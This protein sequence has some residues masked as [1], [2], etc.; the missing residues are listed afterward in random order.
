MI[1]KKHIPSA[2][3][4]SYIESIGYLEGNN[5]GTGLPKVAM[6][7]VF[8]LADSF[9]LF[10]DAS[11]SRY[12]DF[13]K[14][15]IAGLQ[16]KPAH[17]ASYGSSKMIIIQFRSLGA[18]LFLRDSL[19]HYTN[20]FVTLD[21]VFSRK[22]DLVWEQLMAADSFPK[23][24][25]IAEQ[26]LLRKMIR[27]KEP[28]SKLQSSI[29]ILLTGH[30][31]TT[32]DQLCRMSNISRKHLN[33]LSKEFTGVSPK[34]IASLNRLQSALKTISTQPKQT[35]TAT[36]Y[37][38]GYFDQAHFIN[39]FRKFTTMTPTDYARIAQSHKE[40]QMVPHFIPFL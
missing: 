37:D 26:F 23:Q 24:I 38:L 33:T 1:Y 19:H 2:P 32:I 8:N 29:E 40:T 39:D 6:S 4:N 36:A 12:S 17:V 3:L 22:A 9:K 11:F 16:T 28:D 7:M 30:Q 34:T 15:W 14:H 31:E 21:C 35:L 18:S 5:K 13:R 25:L 27:N 20:E 10:E